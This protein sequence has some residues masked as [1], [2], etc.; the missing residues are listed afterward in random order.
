MTPFEQPELKRTD[1]AEP[2]LLL[3]SQGVSHPFAFS[4]LEAP[5]PAALSRTRCDDGV[6]HVSAFSPGNP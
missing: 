1:L 5:P 6:G 2:L 4:W 3:L